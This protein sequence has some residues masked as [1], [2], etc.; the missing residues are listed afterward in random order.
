MYQGMLRLF[1]QAA[2]HGDSEL[3]EPFVEPVATVLRE[4]IGDMLVAAADRGE[5]RDDVDLEAT[6]RI[7]HALAVAV[8]GSLLLPYL[9]RYLQVTG[10]QVSQE[11]AVQA[12]VD[13]VL[14]GIGA[15]TVTP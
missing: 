10:D 2:Y 14:N 5:I 7:I 13:L 9:N 15:G 6:G 1:A 12:L 8:G 3:T 11:R 4:T